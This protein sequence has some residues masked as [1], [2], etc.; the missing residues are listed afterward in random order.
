[1]HVPENRYKIRTQITVLKIK[2]CTSNRRIRKARFKQDR[3]AK[4]DNRFGNERQIAE[5]RQE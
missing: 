2:G 1:M 5:G 3:H 4:T